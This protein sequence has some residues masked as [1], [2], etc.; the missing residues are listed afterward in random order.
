MA[1]DSQNF[2][3]HTRMVPG[4]HYVTFMLA[5]V[6][7]VWSVVRAF[8]MPAAETLYPLAGA[9][10]LIGI[11]WY[12]RVFALQAQNRTIRLEERL[13]LAR[14]LPADHQGNVDAIAPSQL[15]AL[16]FAPDSEVTDLAR[17]V[18]ANPSMTAKE[19]KAQIKNWRADH[20]R[21]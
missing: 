5:A 7:A 8:R 3:N 2:S 6:F 12:A 18:I 15:I 13:R 17:K 19:I 16:R 4:Y 20:Y 10:A 14:L 1:N 11:A 9:L 21:V